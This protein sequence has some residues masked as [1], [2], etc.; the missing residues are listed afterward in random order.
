MNTQRDVE[1]LALELELN[2]ACACSHPWADHVDQSPHFC[3]ECD[4]RSFTAAEPLLADRRAG[5][6]YD[7]RKDG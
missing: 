4:C 3:V 5:V 6:E 1:I 7:P 2:T